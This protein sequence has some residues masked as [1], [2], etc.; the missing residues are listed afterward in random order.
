VPAKPVVKVTVW[1]T[2]DDDGDDVMVRVAGSLVTGS[3]KLTGLLLAANA[4]S[5]NTMP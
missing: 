1:S 2:V 5:R 3:I 4:G